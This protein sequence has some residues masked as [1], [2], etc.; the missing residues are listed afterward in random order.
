MVPFGAQSAACALMGE[1]IGAN[2]VPMAKKYFTVIAILTLVL[3]LC[4]QIAILT[5]RSE[6]ID[7]L[8]ANREVRILAKRYL[9]IIVIGF[10]PDCI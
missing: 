1:K 8:T 2:Q 9:P 3:M 10:T 7:N 6:I 5:F 4:V